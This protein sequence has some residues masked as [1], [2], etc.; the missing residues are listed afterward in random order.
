MW[1]SNPQIM[2]LQIIF[3]NGPTQV[4]N[5]LWPSDTHHMVTEILVNIGSSNGLLP[6]GTK[7]LPEVLNQCWLEII[8]IH[9]SA[10]YWNMCK[11]Y[12]QEL[13]FEFF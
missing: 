12:W 3:Q 13:S 10:I 5:P 6:D 1:N 7:P 2:S 4:A 8:S 9:P 11:I